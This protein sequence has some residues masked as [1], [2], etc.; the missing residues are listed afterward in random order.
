MD[1]M[2]GYF[3]STIFYSAPTEEFA[4]WEP[5][6]SRCLASLSYTDAYRDAYY[7][8]EKTTME[9]FAANTQ[10]YNE[11][12]DMI[13]SGWEA[14]Q[15]TYDLLSEKRSDAMLGYD[16][17]YDSETGEVY[18][19]YSGFLEDYEGTRYEQASDDM[20]TNYISGYIVGIE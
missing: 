13:T 2:P 14:R 1:L 16:R 4:E 6:L 5:I 17:V 7:K 19:T 10:I 12:S 20:Y 11:I 8:Q 15:S 9:A 18:K 3:Y